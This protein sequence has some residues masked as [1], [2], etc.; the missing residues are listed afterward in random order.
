L[1]INLL[2]R[3]TNR[4]LSAELAKPPSSSKSA[5]PKP[6]NQKPADQNAA[7]ASSSSSSADSTAKPADTTSP[8]YQGR[9]CFDTTI[10]LRMTAQPQCGDTRKTTNV[11]IS[12]PDL[13]Q[14][15]LTVYLRSPIGVFNYYGKLLN[16]QPAV[17]YPYYF[18]YQGRDLV[19]KEPFL[20]VVR[21][22]STNCFVRVGFGGETFCVP[23]SS[24]HTALLMTLLLHLRNL[25]IQPSDLNS[26]FSVHLSGT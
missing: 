14:V 2:G 22:G 11:T 4:G 13:G 15:D 21:D 18:T 6:A 17:W 7:A 26:A 19:G 1:F 23:S 10:S 5:A 9:F 8:S 25:N 3:L 20:N 24:R 16:K 12:F